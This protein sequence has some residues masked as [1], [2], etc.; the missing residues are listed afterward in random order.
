MFTW[1]GSTGAALFLKSIASWFISTTV[2]LPVLIASF[3]AVVGQYLIQQGFVWAGYLTTALLTAGLAIAAGIAAWPAIALAAMVGLGLAI[4]NYLIGHSL[5]DDIPMWFAEVFNATAEYFKTVGAML[6]APFMEIWSFIN[7]TITVIAEYATQIG[8][9]LINTIVS[10]FDS[11]ATLISTS[12]NAIWNFMSESINTVIGFAK[13]I[14]DGLI[15]TI[16]DIIIG[17]KDIIV[18]TLTTIWD[19]IKGMIDIVVEIGGNIGKGLMDAISGAIE[20]GVDAINAVL[21]GIVSAA[22]AT[23]DKIMAIVNLAKSAASGISNL[24]TSGTLAGGTTIQLGEAMMATGGIIK[25]QQGGTLVRAAEAGKNEAYVPLPDGNSIPV[26]F[27]NLPDF[28][29]LSGNASNNVNINFGDV[30]INNDIDEREFFKRVE[31]TVSNALIRR[32]GRR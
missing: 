23:Y 32:N 29:A 24:A 19:S 16:N 2:A 11:G 31:S 15:N 8:E 5:I 7:E 4:Y 10:L 18:S 22:Q 6:S 28:S 25:A 26:S 12:F 30:N 9:T 14:A 13:E 20:A 3:S 27:S 17:G 1:L 21:D